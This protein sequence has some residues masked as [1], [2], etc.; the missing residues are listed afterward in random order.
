MANN[1]DRP[2][3]EL[4]TGVDDVT[5]DDREPEPPLTPEERPRGILTPTDREYL[6][7]L[8]EYAQPQ[9]DANRRQDIRERVANGLKDFVL[10]SLFLEPDEREKIFEAFGPEETEDVLAAMVAF[11]YL[12]LEGDRPRLETCI[13]HGVLQ[14]ANVDKLF[15]SSG[16]ATNVDVSISVEYNPDIEKLYR[17]FEDGQELTDAE[18]GALVRAGKINGDEIEE[19]VG[20]PRGFPGVFAGR[21]SGD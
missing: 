10:L 7:G 8:K 9:T 6:C 3:D 1:S 11:G 15:Q 21:G 13:E 5:D 4:F 17:R 2:T 12:G 20:S 19:L 16:R 18:V 14:G